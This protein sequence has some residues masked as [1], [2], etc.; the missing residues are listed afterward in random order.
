MTP[1]FA[2]SAQHHFGRAAPGTSLGNVIRLLTKLT[3][4]LTESKLEVSVCLVSVLKLEVRVCLVPVLPG[5][6]GVP[7]DILSARP[8]PTASDRRATPGGGGAKCR[9]GTSES[10]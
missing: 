6:L 1:A 7:S 3:S 5:P 4:V 8:P 9:E 2:L 10:R